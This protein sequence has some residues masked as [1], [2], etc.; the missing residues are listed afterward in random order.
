MKQLDIV[1]RATGMLTPFP[2]AA[3]LSLI[4]LIVST[5]LAEQP[6][7]PCNQNKAAL[8][9]VLI[10][11]TR[12]DVKKLPA[13]LKGRLLRMADRPHS[14]LPT[15]AF[16]EAGTPSQLFQYYLLDTNGFE[17][18]N[19]TAIFPGV[20]DGV[21]ATAANAANCN[22]PTLGSIRV[23]VEPKPGLP[24]DPN[25]PGAFIDIFT[26][27]SNLFVINNE[28]GWYEGWM[29]H[30]LTVPRVARPRPS[31]RAQFG[32][33]T[34]ADATALATMGS[35]HNVPG[36]IFTQDGKPAHLP[37]A[38]DHFPNQQTNLVPIYLSMGAYNCLQ[39]ADCHAYWEFQSVHR[40]GAS[41][42]R[43]AR[44]RRFPG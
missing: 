23:V 31:G 39:G 25:D 7:A 38:S 11:S 22:L 30:D 8:Q 17:P 20:N 1:N 14:A 4:P 2:V 44:H 41:L 34:A 40:L 28:S 27:I 29:I 15:Q 10:T 35:H 43:A 9:D 12:A 37:S 42:V 16:A 21:G 19:F 5:A 6:P 18:N 3:I 24:T 32:T 13:P 26:D 36:A 33:I